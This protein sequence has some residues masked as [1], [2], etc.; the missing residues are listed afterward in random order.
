MGSHT[1]LAGELVKTIV[2]RPVASDTA[3]LGANATIP[4]SP[5]LNRQPR[6]K[7]QQRPIQSRRNAV[8]CGQEASP[9]SS[10]LHYSSLVRR[11]LAGIMRTSNQVAL[12]ADSTFV[13]WNSVRLLTKVALPQHRFALRLADLHP[14]S[15]LVSAHPALERLHVQ[16]DHGRDVEGEQL[17]DEQSAHHRQAQ[18]TA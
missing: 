14:L 2:T 8:R 13:V 7:Q 10:D 18:R 16:I 12:C 4:S 5:C 9:R 6:T 11:S 17:G 3:D 1:N 15:R